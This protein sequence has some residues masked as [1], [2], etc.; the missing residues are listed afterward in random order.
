VPRRL[1]LAPRATELA[2]GFAAL[3]AELGVPE[4]YPEAAAAE[5]AAAADAYAGERRD[6]TDVAFVTIDPPGS[7]DLDQAFHAE[8]RGGG[9]RVRYAIADPGAFV[10]P[11]GPLDEE[12]RARGVTLYSPDK[13][14]PLYPTALSEGRAS[15]LD[16]ADV[17][18]VLWTLDLDAA[19]EPA[20]VTVE[21]A[22]V[23]SRARLDYETVQRA[24]DGGTA[25]PS[26][27]LLRDVGTLRLERERD[28][29][30]VSLPTPDQEV[31]AGD[32]GYALRYRPRLPVETWNAQISLLT[33]IA[34]AR[35]MLDGGLG[36]LRTMPEPVPEDVAELRRSA[37]ALGVAWPEEMPYAARVGSLVPAVPAQAA[38]LNL[39]A[40]LMRGA[41]Y[42]AF[43]G[44]PPAQAEHSAVA[45]PYAHVTAPLRRLADRFA[46]E[47]VL[48]LHAGREVPAWCRDSLPAL[49]D[50]MVAADRRARTLEREVLDYVEAVV[51]APRVGEAFDAVVVGD[52]VVQ[53]ADPAVRGRYKGAAE[54]GTAVRVRLAEVDVAQRRVR[55]GD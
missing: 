34:G 19:G 12:S 4:A 24:I 29:G 2:A 53:L 42:T 28:R 51:L 11:G 17:P 54:P 23:R 49:P 22:T 16:G 50:L 36:L 15:L 10:T 14:T 39:A 31:V 33:G 30:G 7:R 35:V 40:T 27:A 21:R 18:A 5:A 3:R 38:L 48:A 32:G 13:R 52:G 55:F 25:D 41:G 37:A 6:A 47:V 26:L 1:R 46:N 43:D 9:Y 44:A 20:A 8:R 45:A